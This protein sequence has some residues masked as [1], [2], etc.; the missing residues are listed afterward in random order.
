MLLWSHFDMAGWS[1]AANFTLHD[2]SGCQ[3][4]PAELPDILGLALSSH[5]PA[6]ATSNVPA[7]PTI[8]PMA[9][10]DAHGGCNEVPSGSESMPPIDPDTTN[11]TAAMSP[12]LGPCTREELS[13]GMASGHG[14]G[15]S[16]DPHSCQ[17]VAATKVSLPQ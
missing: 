2:E 9:S 8:S 5:P 17:L 3:P 7:S 11:S 12:R 16:W 1:R 15:A 6:S 4:W 10:A 14:I 13:I